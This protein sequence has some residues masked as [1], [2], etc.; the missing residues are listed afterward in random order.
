MAL[1]KCKTCGHNLNFT[2]EKCPNCGFPTYLNRRMT[3]TGWI[4]F[5]G[6]A[7]AVSGTLINHLLYS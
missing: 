1:T 3:S 6:L 2:A 4:V 5:I 7:I